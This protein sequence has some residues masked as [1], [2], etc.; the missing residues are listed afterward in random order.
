MPPSSEDRLTE[1]LSRIAPGGGAIG[2]DVAALGGL[3]DA[4]ATVDHQIE[5]THY[6]PGTDP[7]LVAR[8]LLEVNLSDLAAAGA[9][10]RCALLSLAAPPDYDHRRFLRSLAEACRRRAVALVGG[11]TARAEIVSMSLTLVGALSPAGRMLR[12]SNARPNDRLWLGGSLG[13]AATGRRLLELGARIEGRGVLLPRRFRRP[14]SIAGAATRAVRRQLQPTAQIELG[15][16]LGRRQRVAAI[17]V[18][19]G[20]ALDLARLCRASDVGASIRAE[21]L[22]IADQA[23]R[24]AD[25]LGHPLERLVLGGGED[26]VLLFSLPPGSRPPADF[27]C[28]EIGRIVSGHGIE[29]VR[30][31]KAR[32]LE[33]AG[34]SHLDD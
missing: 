33:P 30:G 18:S 24:I 15:L 8:R 4:V 25:R 5:G 11:D 34:W 9:R 2:D 19:D 26:Y 28:T 6:P 32:P 3:E 12:R 16:H 23:A 22:P 1:W 13:E 29:I 17:D 27:P 14:A 20:L 7:A 31:G 10:P 21:A